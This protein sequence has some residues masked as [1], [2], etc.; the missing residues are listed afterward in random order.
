MLTEDTSRCI[1]QENGDNWTL[2]CGDSCEV[3][4]GLPDCSIDFGVHSPPFSNLYIYSNSEAD[5]GNSAS[6]DEFFQHYRFIIQEMH[7]ITV[8]GRLCAVHCKDLPKYANRDD[9][10]G[11]IDFPGRIIRTFEECGWSYHSRITIWKCP[12]TERERTNNNG[13][14][15]KT[16]VRDRSQ[17]RQGMA[18]YLLLFRK[19]PVGTLMSDKP[20]VDV[21]PTMT[22]GEEATGFRYYVG[23]CSPYES[24]FHPS[25]FS[26]KK[27]PSDPSI[28]IWQ[29][30]AEPV[31]WDIDQTDVL[32]YKAGRTENDERHICPLQM[33]VIE[34]AIDIWSNRGDVVFTPFA[35]VGSEL[36]GSIRRQ[37][38]AVGIELKEAY[39]DIAVK[40]LRSAERKALQV[41]QPLL[42]SGAD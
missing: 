36:V 2:Y 9:T 34:R 26:R 35:G 5:L 32:N 3:I 11:L 28:A 42:A 21:R 17:L 8:V 1:N 4:K 41:Q 18:D 33:G 31:W 12:V 24:N 23:E 15:H 40:N 13:L 19:P 22:D 38:K 14:L 27:R 29:R 25:K 6:D 10:A 7:R 20:V 37:R 16:A 30:Y 39:F